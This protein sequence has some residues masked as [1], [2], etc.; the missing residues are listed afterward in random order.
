MASASAASFL[1]GGHL[2]SSQ[3]HF[4]DHFAAFINSVNLKNIFGKIKAIL[5][6]FIVDAPIC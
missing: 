5:L 2:F 6:I 4:L 1:I 3:L